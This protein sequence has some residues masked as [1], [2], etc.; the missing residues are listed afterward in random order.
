[1]AAPL[2]ATANT[3]TVRMTTTSVSKTFASGQ[4]YTFVP[5]VPASCSDDMWQLNANVSGGT[6][7]YNYTWTVPSGQSGLSAT[8]VANPTVTGVPSNTYTVT[9][10]DGCSPKVRQ[11]DRLPVQ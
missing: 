6:P 4:T 5:S 9:V 2:I 10:T 1:M 11:A 3:A 7:P 8:N